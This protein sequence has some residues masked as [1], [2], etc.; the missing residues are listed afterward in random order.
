MNKGWQRI[1]LGDL[2]SKSD[3]WIILDSETEYKEVTVR[4]WGRGVAMR[5]I[6]SGTS[7][8]GNRRIRVRSGEFIASRIDARNGAFGLIPEELDGAIVTNDFPVFLV[9]EQC[10]L[11]GYL[12]WLSKTHDFV[13]ACKAASEGTTNRV[14]LKE[15]ASCKSNSPAPAGRAAADRGEDRAAGGEDRGGAGVAGCIN[16][17]ALT[18]GH[19]PAS[20]I[21][22]KHAYCTA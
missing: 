13:E 9:D 17:I 20:E 12:H 19:K 16:A 8:A 14:R 22:F 2:L 7:V 21:V 5:G 4:L 6:V 15:V 11:P 10:M 1:R 18:I 3:R